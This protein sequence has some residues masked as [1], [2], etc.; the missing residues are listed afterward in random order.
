MSRFWLGCVVA[1][2][3]VLAAE[4]VYVRFGFVDPRA[5]IGVNAV[6]KRVA[7]PALDAAVDRRAA[8]TKNPV[9]PTDEEL[10]AGM[11]LYEANCSSCHGDIGRPEGMF[12]R[13]LYPRPPQFVK[14]A[15]DMT[16]DQNYF[17]IEHGVRLSGMPAWG[18][19]LSQQQMWQLTTFLSHMNQLPPQVAVGWKRAA[20]GG[21]T[22]ASSAPGG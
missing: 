8:K 12:A 1:A 17:I 10:T 7:M 3:A 19:I 18:G 5:D 4:F 22:G 21:N 6:E 13:A 2:I 15:P 11:Q 14:D 20:A 9:L 16:E